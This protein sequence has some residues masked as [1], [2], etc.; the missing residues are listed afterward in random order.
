M[1]E[2][3]TQVVAEKGRRIVKERRAVVVSAKSQETV[4]VTVE[5]R[6]KHP[7]YKK[8]LTVRKRFAA[9]DTLGCQEGDLV[10]IRETRP[11]SKTKRWRVFKKLA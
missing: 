3:D 8:Y 5:R 6:V 4:I 2:T 9:H 1:S 11:M 7:K 10:L